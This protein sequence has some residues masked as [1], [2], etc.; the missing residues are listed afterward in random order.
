MK[1]NKID[2]HLAGLAKKK[3]RVRTLI[4]KIITKR[5]DIMIH[6]TDSRRS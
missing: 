3:K 1:R 5:R 4:Y 2:K 6:V